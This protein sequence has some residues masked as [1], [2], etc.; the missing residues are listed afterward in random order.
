MMRTLTAVSAFL[1]SL[2]LPTST[3]SLP[4]SPSSKSSSSTASIWSTSKFHGVNLGGWLVQEKSLDTKWWESVAPNATDEWTMCTILGPERCSSVLEGRYATWITT[5]TIDTLASVGVD[6]LRIPS[7]YAA[8]IDLP[9]SGL[10]SGNQLVYL[11]YITEYAIS[12][13]GMH[14]ILDIHSLPGGLN[15][16]DI[17]EKVGNWGWFFNA[18]AWSQSLDVM[19]KVVEFIASSSSPNSFTLEPMNEPADLNGDDNLGMSVFGT[20]AALSDEGA[21]YVMA[22]WKA[23]LSRVRSLESELGLETNGIPIGLQSFKLPS[24]WG[25]NFTSSD[26]VLFDMHNYYF[27][28]RNTTSANLESYMLSDAEFKQP[29]RDVQIPV[30]IGEWAIQAA[31]NNEFELRGENVRRGLEIWKEHMSGSAYWAARFEGLDEVDGQ[32]TKRDYWSFER[33]IELGY[34]D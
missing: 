9:G 18:T 16:L 30:F 28:G 13:Y 1:L 11:R 23:V 32:G 34:F 15:G 12:T 22:F 31:S 6:L 24:Y 20:P 10:Y 4:H 17:G 14:I 5:D 8:W 2:S 7:T 25:K 3:T 33:F 27:E 29:L 21:G 26:N 19:E